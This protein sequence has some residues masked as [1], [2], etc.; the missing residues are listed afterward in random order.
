[1]IVET[2]RPDANAHDR[3]A[4]ELLR[5]FRFMH[6]LEAACATRVEPFR[7]GT[8][9]FN[10][11]F[12]DLYFL[13][14]LRTDRLPTGT[15]SEDL[16]EEAEDL[17]SRAGHAHR[18]VSVHEEAGADFVEGFE[19]LGWKT[20]CDLVMVHR[21]DL[22]AP[23]SRVHVAEIDLDSLHR[24]RE[25]YIRTLPHGDKEG[26]VRQLLGKDLLLTERANARYFGALVGGEVVCACDLYSDG[27]TAQIEDVAT[28]EEHRGRGYASAVVGSAVEAARRSGHDVIFLL[29]EEADWPKDLYRKLGFDA[30]GRTFDFWKP[31]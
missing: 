20:E 29:A 10:D 17:H 23:E 31:A 1:L 18:K 11:H 15:R 2:K 13:N 30:V 24:M 27:R 9:F 21:R 16:A 5:I 28:L 8:A 22:Q 12:P 14:F 25:P 7:F 19:S 3:S 6:A 4:S 26:V